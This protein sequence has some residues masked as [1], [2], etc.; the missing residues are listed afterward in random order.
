MY[1]QLELAFKIERKFK[2]DEIQYIRFE[3]NCVFLIN[4]RVIHL[5]SNILFMNYLREKSSIIIILIIKIY[6][7][8]N[9]IKN[10]SL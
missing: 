3:K 7:N 2:F 10:Q 6:N 4:N 8:Y 9:N 5:N 1:D